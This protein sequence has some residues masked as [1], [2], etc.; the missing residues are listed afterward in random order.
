MARFM[1]LLY[2]RPHDFSGYSPE[3]IQAVTQEYVNWRTKLAA[4]G[5]ILGGDK[6]YDGQGRSMKVTDG[7]LRITDGPYAEVKEVLGGYFAIQAADYDEAVELSKDCPH[8]K[9]GGTIDVRQIEEM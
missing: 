9:F 8:L 1:L 7:Q 6:L 4:D 5:K 2:E 3:E